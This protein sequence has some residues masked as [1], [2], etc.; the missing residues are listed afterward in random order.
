MGEFAMA[1][2]ARWQPPTLTG[3]NSLQLCF[4]GL[5]LWS[6]GALVGNANKGAFWLHLQRLITKLPVLFVSDRLDP[7]IIIPRHVLV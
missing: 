2:L 6:M 5:L 7:E 1:L 3:V 4:L